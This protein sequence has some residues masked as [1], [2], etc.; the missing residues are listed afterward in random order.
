MTSPK[1]NGLKVVQEN[2]NYKYKKVL[3]KFKNIDDIRRALQFHL[4]A[5]KNSIN[6]RLY[7]C[8]NVVK[9]I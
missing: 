4:F 9:F 1:G 5:V 8:D 7:F 2:H 6:K 3:C